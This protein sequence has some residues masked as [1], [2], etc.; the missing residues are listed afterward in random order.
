MYLPDDIMQEVK[1][2]LLPPCGWLDE[3]KLDHVE[4]VRSAL[5]IIDKQL[6]GKRF[7]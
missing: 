3:E 7:K 1:E 5:E 2:K 6:D 4:L